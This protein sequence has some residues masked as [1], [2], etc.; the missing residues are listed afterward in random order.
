M[1]TRM[2][3]RHT[4]RREPSSPALW[5]LSSSSALFAYNNSRGNDTSGDD[6]RL[7]ATDMNARTLSL[8]PVRPHRNLHLHRH[9]HNS[10]WQTVK[11]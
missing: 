5:Q 4:R 10:L 6:T 1:F 9:G 8:R 7:P 11:L 2:L 3:S